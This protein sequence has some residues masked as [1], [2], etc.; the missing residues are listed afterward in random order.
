M[1]SKN[2]ILLIGGTLVVAYLLFRK[3]ESNKI[4]PTGQKK[5]VEF[6]PIDVQPMPWVAI[7]NYF[8]EVK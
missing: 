5:L 2:N 7:P 6:E 3:K 8:P 1:L 4:V